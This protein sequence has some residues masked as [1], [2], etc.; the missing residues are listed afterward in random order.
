MPDYRTMY[1][2][3]CATASEALD[4]LPEIPETE[5]ARKLLLGGLDEAEEFYIDDED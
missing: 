4:A 3:L 2:I 1:C 5:A